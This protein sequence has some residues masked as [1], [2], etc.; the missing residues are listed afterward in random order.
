MP[1]LSAETET[2]FLDIYRQTIAELM[3]RDRQVLDEALR[4][5]TTAFAVAK[6]LPSIPMKTGYPDLPDL[7]SPHVAAIA[8]GIADYEAGRFRDGDVVMAELRA[9]FDIGRKS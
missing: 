8:E 4:S 1:T 6:A 7:P 9:R 3:P 2:D 5:V